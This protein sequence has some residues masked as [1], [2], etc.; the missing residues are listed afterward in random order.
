M[1]A[2]GKITQNS[3]SNKQAFSETE[4][5]QELTADNCPNVLQVI[6]SFTTDNSCVIVT[7][8]MQGNLFNYVCA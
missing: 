8:Y 6:E 5:I 4:I 2:R 1:I 3:L 7:Q